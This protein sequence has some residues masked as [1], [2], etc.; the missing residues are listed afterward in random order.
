MGSGT[1]LIVAFVSLLVGYLA[2]LV[3]TRMNT[4]KSQSEER[5]KDLGPRQE[6]SKLQVLLWRRDEKSP[7]LADVFGKTI[8]SP[9]EL[10]P[11]EKRRFLEELHAI[12]LWFGI[13]KP[14][15]GVLAVPVPE[16]KPETV[17]ATET[18]LPAPASSPTEAEKPAVVEQTTAPVVLTGEELELIPPAPLP[19]AEPKMDLPPIHLTP[20]Y[21][22]TPVEP[23]KPVEVKL[24]L[25]SKPKPEPVMKSIVQQIDDILQDKVARSPLAD[26]GVKLQETPQGVLVWVGNQSYQGVDALPEG[27]AKTLIHAAVKDW[28]KR[29]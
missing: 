17:L 21:D 11:V 7:V 25:R 23:V 27:E 15:V 18:E 1:I 4:P 13:I 20:V 28:E 22:P 19:V 26:T 3:L 2:G 5:I 10:L 9:N 12:Q 8:H 14:S 16:E 24:D 29:G 6:V